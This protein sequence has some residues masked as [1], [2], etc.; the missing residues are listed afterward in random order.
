MQVHTMGD[1]LMV[2]EAFD[3]SE[4]TPDQ[5]QE[6][7]GQQ[8]CYIVDDG[9]NDIMQKLVEQDADIAI[10]FC[11]LPEVMSAVKALGGSADLCVKALEAKFG[12]ITGLIEIIYTGDILVLQL[13]VDAKIKASYYSSLARSCPVIHVLFSTSSIC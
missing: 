5:I 7:A 4:S 10:T 11:L 1:Q 12:I 2:C 6:L 9:A 3:I 8:K 13:V